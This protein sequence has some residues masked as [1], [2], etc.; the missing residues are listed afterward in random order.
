M[1]Y[2]GNREEAQ[3]LKLPLLDA[4]R[5]N[6]DA[7]MSDLILVANKV[8]ETLL[9]CAHVQ[10]QLQIAPLHIAILM[11]LMVRLYKLYDS[12]IFLICDHRLEIALLIGRSV[13]DTAIDLT[14]LCNKL[15]NKEFT[16]FLKSSLATGRRIFDEV[17]SDKKDGRGHPFIQSRIQTSILED[18]N[19]AGYTLEDVKYSDRNLFGTAA[20]RASE[21]DLNRLYLFIYKNLSRIIHGSWSELNKYHLMKSNGLWY[22]NPKYSIPKPSIIDGTSVMVLEAT[23]KYVSTVAPGF[24]LTE[25]LE[26]LR[27]WFLD[28]AHKHEQ[29]MSQQK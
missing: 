28:M 2:K 21:N 25:R 4:K 9:I 12:V 20:S 5:E 11:G 26:K 3:P 18:F 27:K 1:E 15:S 13:C 6:D 17:E 23:E 24:E 22:P 10:P 29:F 16:N 19:E 7:F 14:F 8:R